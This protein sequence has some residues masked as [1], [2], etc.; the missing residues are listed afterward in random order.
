[1]RLALDGARARLLR[2][3]RHGRRAHF[4]PGPALRGSWLSP[5]DALREAGRARR[6]R[7]ATGSSISLILVELALAVV[8]LTM[9]GS[10][11][12]RSGIWRTPTSGSGRRKVLTFEMP[13]FRYE[14]FQRRV[15]FVNAQL[16]RIRAVP[17]VLAAGAISRM[18][19]TPP[20]RPPLSVP[21]PDEAD[22]TKQVALFRMVT[23]EYFPTVGARLREGRFFETSD[24]RSAP[25]VGDRQRV[26]L[27]VELSR[28]L[29]PRE[30]L[31]F[32]Q[33]G[34]EGYWYTIVGVVERLRESPSRKSRGPRSICCTSRRI[35][36]GPRE[37]GRAGSSS[38]PRGTR[39]GRPAL[40]QAIRSV[41][42][43][44]PM[45]RV[46]TLEEIVDR[47]LS[48]PRQTTALMGAFAVL[49]LLLA[50]LGIY[51]VLSYAVTSARARSVCAWRWVRA[52]WRY[53]SPSQARPGPDPQRARHW[54]GPG[55]HRVA[56]DE[57]PALRLPA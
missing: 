25:P 55:R 56:F 23:R 50:A 32:G 2:R 52:P 7:A 35:N 15:L 51:G 38:A 12:R 36:S 13:L 47:Q 43:N 48:T 3:R 54:P 19:L 18:P 6:A 27:P 26:P 16:E 8:L 42:K 44:Q 14:D 40:R 4:W 5:Q 37:P 49:A 30:R 20:T 41:D 53:C 22:I 11:C 39:H 1:L 29:A 24:Q 33:L 34:E 9:A 10:S 31:K 57:R 21:R 45:W 46:E 17:G 28:P